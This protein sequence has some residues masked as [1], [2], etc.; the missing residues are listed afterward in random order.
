MSDNR[1]PQNMVI[2]GEESLFMDPV[3][4]ADTYNSPPVHT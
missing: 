3:G 2:A 1:G 4:Q